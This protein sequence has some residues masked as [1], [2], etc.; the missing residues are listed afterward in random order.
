MRVEATDESPPVPEPI[1]FTHITPAERP[2]SDDETTVLSRGKIPRSDDQQTMVGISSVI[3]APYVR[4]SAR[5]DKKLEWIMLAVIVVSMIVM[6]V[7]F[8]V[9]VVSDIAK[10]RSVPPV[11]QIIVS[12]VAR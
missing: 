6:F 9:I 3:E 1:L 2:W 4:R 12:Q 8:G 7:V 11:P 5:I 10:L